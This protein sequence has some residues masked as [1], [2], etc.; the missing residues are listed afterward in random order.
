[1]LKSA[2]SMKEKLNL[3]LDLFWNNS[4]QIPDECAFRMNNRATTVI[5]EYVS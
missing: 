2:W 5:F 3:G 4:G 1:M